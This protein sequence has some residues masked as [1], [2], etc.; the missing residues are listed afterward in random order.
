MSVLAVIL[1]T[2]SLCSSAL[3]LGTHLATSIS[4]LIPTLPYR[5]TRRLLDPLSVLLGLGSWIAA[6]LLC[7]FPPASAWR[8]QVLFA[9]AFAP[10]GC[11]ARFYVSAALNPLIPSF[12]LGTFAVNVFGTAVLGMAFDL[13]HVRI[14]GTGSVSDSPGG[15]VLGCQVLQGVMDGFCGALTTV[16]T[17]IAEM[18]SLGRGHAYAYA[19]A[20]LGAGIGVV[21][22]V[23]GSV[24]WS[25]G[26]EAVACVT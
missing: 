14:A 9:I 2:L 20:S 10:A 26:W 6:I 25:I 23:M 24:R 3:I 15:G 5:L 17:W 7:I 19:V 21:V 22:V 4:R 8:A 1:I 13:Q 16:S 18:K 11:L 12:P